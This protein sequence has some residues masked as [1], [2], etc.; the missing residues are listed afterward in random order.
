[1]TRALSGRG[2]FLAGCVNLLRRGGQCLHV[3][4][5]LIGRAGHRSQ[6]TIDRHHER[7]LRREQLQELAIRLTVHGRIGVPDAPET[8]ELTRVVERD[9]HFRARRF[10]ARQYD[11]IW[12]EPMRHEGAAQPQRFTREARVGIE[13]ERRGP[14]L[15]CRVGD[16]LHLTR[17]RIVA[18]KS[19]LFPGDEL[20]RQLLHSLEAVTQGQ[21]CRDHLGEPLNQMELVGPHAQ[22]QHTETAPG[23]ERQ[24]ADEQGARTA[25]NRCVYNRE[26]AQRQG[27]GYEVDDRFPPQG[28]PGIDPR[29]RLTQSELQVERAVHDHRQHHDRECDD[30]RIVGGKCRHSR[31][32]AQAGVHQSHERGSCRQMRRVPQRRAEREA[33]QQHVPDQHREGR[34]DRGKRPATVED[35]EQHDTEDV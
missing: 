7:E 11:L 32:S 18:S 9:E 2:D 5:R 35:P 28:E 34:D 26:P 1:M 3:L 10:A 13:A 24:R 20:P 31:R 21:L 17:A 16:K 33:A 25:R 14:W 15:R 12:R 30:P 8:D 22:A 23:R 19:H 4:R 27:G 29:D 6:R